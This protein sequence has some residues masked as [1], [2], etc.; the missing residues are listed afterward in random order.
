MIWGIN[1]MKDKISNELWNSKCEKDNKSEHFWERIGIIENCSD[2]NL[3]WRCSQC[4]KCI[5]EPLSFL[6]IGDD[7]FRM[8][9]EQENSR[10][11]INYFFKSVKDHTKISRKKFYSILHQVYYIAKEENKNAQTK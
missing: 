9:E 6:E 10:K 11:I 8:S 3:I 2:I 4:K 7:S 5:S 1:D